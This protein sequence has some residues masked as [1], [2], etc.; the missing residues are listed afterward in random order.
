MTFLKNYDII[1]AG[2]GTAGAQSL[3]TA[4]KMGFKVLG[5]EKLSYI[6]GTNTAGVTEFLQP[7][8]CTH[9]FEIGRR[10]VL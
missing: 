9:R 5:I 4:A 1:V 8:L 2:L 7:G 3:I 10:K 6:G